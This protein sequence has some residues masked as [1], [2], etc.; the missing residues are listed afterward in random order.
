MSGRTV[1]IV[2][3]YERADTVAATVTALKPLADEVVVVDDGSGDATA[4][5][6]ADAGARV[7]RLAANVGKGGAVTAGVRAA[8]DAAVYLLVDADTGDTAAATTALLGPVLAG[9]VDMTIA[10]LPGAGRSGGFGAV[11][12]LA[13]AGIRRACGFEA[14]A[15]LSGQRAVRGDLLRS[16]VPLAR[17]F[18]LETAL[19]I[20]AVRAGARVVEVPVDMGHRATGR[21]FAGFVHRGRQGL[22][23]LAAL[24]PRLLGRGHPRRGG[25]APAHWRGEHR[26]S[27]V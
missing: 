25:A 21:S 18:G 11:R 27:E 1:A 20:D 8:P 12:R 14:T 15:P 26:E 3:A 17:R 10:V 5:C 22:D 23:I 9:D 6:A 2:A 7:V 16:L 4:A 19:T 24:R 13:A